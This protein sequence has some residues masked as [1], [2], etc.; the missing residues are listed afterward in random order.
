MIRFFRHAPSPGLVSLATLAAVLLLPSVCW[1]LPTPVLLFFMAEFGAQLGLLAIAASLAFAST[2]EARLYRLLPGRAARWGTFGLAVGL[3]VGLYFQFGPQPPVPTIRELSL[4]ERLATCAP[5]KTGPARL[6]GLKAGAVLL[7]P[8]PRA[9]FDSFHILGSCNLSRAEVLGSP[10]VRQRLSSGNG[11]VILVTEL[12]L[13]PAAFFED[14]PPAA[15]DHL[16][17]SQLLGGIEGY[18]KQRQGRDNPGAPNLVVDA[19]GKTISSLGDSED[20]RAGYNTMIARD[21]PGWRL[22]LPA[23]IPQA[24]TSGY[25]VVDVRRVGRA[26]ELGVIAIPPWNAY[27]DELDRQAG[28][29]VK[30]AIFIASYDLPDYLAAEALARQLV[31]RGG[32]APGY[33]FPDRHHYPLDQLSRLRTLPMVSPGWSLVLSW[34]LIPTFFIFSALL[35]WIGGAVASR[36][37]LLQGGEGLS[38]LIIIASKLLGPLIAWSMFA[39]SNTLT[40]EGYTPTLATIRLLDSSRVGW[41][42]IMAL[43]PVCVAGLTYLVAREIPRSRWSTSLFILP[44]LLLVEVTYLIDGLPIFLFLCGAGLAE[45]G[46]KRR[47][48][49]AYAIIFLVIFTNLVNP[50]ITLLNLVL[51]CA[52]VAGQVALI[53]LQRLRYHRRAGQG[54][55][56][57]VPLE[58]LTAGHRAGLKASWLAR[59]ANDGLAVPPGM[60]LLVRPDHYLAEASAGWRRQTARGI[61]RAL[62]KGP[63]VVRSSAPDED[64]EGGSSAGHYLSVTD[65]DSA[66]LEE[67]IQA[68]IKDYVD[69]GIRPDQEVAVLVQPQLRARWA[70]VAVREPVSRGGGLLV[71]ASQGVNFAIT[72]GEGAQRRDRVGRIS[73]RWLLGNLGDKDVPAMQFLRLFQ[74]LELRFS[75][76]LNIEWAWDGGEVYILQVRRVLG[77]GE[78]QRPE[79]DAVAALTR[80]EAGVRWPRGQLHAPVLEMGDLAEFPA[81]GSGATLQLLEELWDTGGPWRRAAGRLGLLG[82]PAPPDPPVLMLDSHYY[83]SGVVDR[84]LR[85]LLGIPTLRLSRLRLR[86]RLGRTLVALDRDLATLES[87]LPDAGLGVSEVQRA[88]DAAVL[89]LARRD[90]LLGPPADIAVAVTLLSQFM[91]GRIASEAGHLE[92]DETDPLFRY[93]AGEGAGEPDW[94]E[95]RRQFPW[96]A[97][98]DLALERP[99]LNEGRAYEG[100]PPLEAP[101]LAA[102]SLAALV[103]LRGRARQVTAWYAVRLRRAYLELGRVTGRVDVFNW[104]LEEVAALARGAS[105][106]EIRKEAEPGELD[107]PSTLTLEALEAWA[108]ESVPVQGEPPGRASGN[109]IGPPR[110]LRGVV[111]DAGDAGGEESPVLVLNTP[112]ASALAAVPRGWAVVAAGGS[113]LCHAALVAR[114]RG[115][116]A[117]FCAGP[118]VLSFQRGQVL[119][120]DK[121]GRITRMLH[122]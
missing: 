104:R 116:P 49:L 45:F 83:Y 94:A 2:A 120:I 65:V 90:E 100:P 77:E 81:P 87:D 9:A 20:P 105:P 29:Q 32:R 31:G 76:L 41:G 54:K 114:Q 58:C 34:F 93:L 113:A 24:L 102:D 57:L 17:W 101:P 1:A 118:G 63:L 35:V 19:R 48:W 89:V 38:R 69:K 11:Q 16:R 62:G 6:L 109:W 5:L 78:G 4:A 108:G 18:L 42:W 73:R 122:G 25:L 99:R 119:T 66:G 36:V 110:E 88:V 82:L 121:K 98:P 92:A 26:R 55:P 75:G 12:G 28:R 61:Q 86:F 43:A 13:G 115:I 23:A 46:L 7:D 40:S 21:L 117:L 85:R 91:R 52:A 51:F 96:R 3:I 107:Y 22:L 80:I 47:G 72:S 106:P 74:R 95:V 37:R 53:W 44:V 111:A 39:F 68:V 112:T 8:R 71:E 67:A 33:V 27:L 103:Q 56:G 15:L 70:G 64:L 97:L 60:V 50:R 79:N 30:G 84:P 10:E 14:A 59:A